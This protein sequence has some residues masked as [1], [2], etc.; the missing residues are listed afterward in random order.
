MRI[1][2]ADV[3][4]EIDIHPPFGSPGHIVARVFRLGLCGSD[5]GSARGRRGDTGRGR[6]CR[7][8][9][10]EPQCQTNTTDPI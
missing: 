2:I 4:K 1:R 7:D 9:D 6:G 5:C 8:R 3:I 10:A